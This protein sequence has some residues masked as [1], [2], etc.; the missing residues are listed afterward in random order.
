MDGVNNPALNGYIQNGLEVFTY[1]YPEEMNNEVFEGMPKIIYLQNYKKG[2][3]T[4]D[5]DSTYN[6][7]YLFFHYI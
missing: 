2:F 7:K 3:I 6:V 4:L 1:G 5:K